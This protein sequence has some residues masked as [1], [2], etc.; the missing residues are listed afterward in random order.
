MSRFNFAGQGFTFKVSAQGVQ[1]VLDLPLPDIQA[2]AFGL[3]NL[4][5]G[6]FFELTIALD[7]K[8]AGAHYTLGLAFMT[9]A[10]KTQSIAELD[11]ALRH[12]RTM[13]Q[14]APDIAEAGYARKNIAAIEE[15]LRQVK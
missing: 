13:V 1:V 5:L 8:L 9:K 2:G 12:F 14:L 6:F 4:R 3:T 11:P 15:A 10:T 7:P